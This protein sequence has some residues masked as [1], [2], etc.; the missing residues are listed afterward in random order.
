VGVADEVR[1]GDGQWM[2][3][4]FFNHTARQPGE[5]NV[6]DFMYHLHHQPAEYPETQDQCHL[7]DSVL[8]FC[9]NL[10]D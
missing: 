6:P 1:T 8:H 4:D 7:W 2:Q 9:L 3:D 10:W 5:D